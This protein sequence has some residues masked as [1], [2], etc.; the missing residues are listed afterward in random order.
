MMVENGK[1]TFSSGDSGYAQKDASLLGSSQSY[2]PDFPVK[3]TEDTM[4]F[5][6]LRHFFPTHRIQALF[7]N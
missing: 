6:G 5:F 4:V 3:I 2:W 7:A 1:V